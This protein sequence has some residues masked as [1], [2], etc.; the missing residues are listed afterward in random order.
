MERVSSCGSVLWLRFT[1][2]T[3]ALS[4][5]GGEGE[6]EPIFMLLKTCVRL[7]REPIFVLF[8]TCVR[9]DRVFSNPEFNSV[10]QVGVA[11]PNTTVSPLSLWERVRVRGS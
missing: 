11:S 2:L 3:P 5:Q 6:R 10:F 4:P 7:E 9:L 1:P 8:K